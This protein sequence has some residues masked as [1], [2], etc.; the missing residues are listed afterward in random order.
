MSAFLIFP[1]QLFEETLAQEAAIFYVVES[2]LFFKQYAFHKQKILFHRA[3]MRAFADRLRATGKT[4]EYIDSL[5]PRASE[6]ALVSSISGPIALFDPNDYLLERRLRRAG[7]IH[8]V[9][10]PNFLNTDTSLLGTRKPYFQTAFYT[11]QR[12]DRGILLEEDGKPMGGQWTFDADNRK[13]IPKNTFIP[14]PF[15]ETAPNEYILEAIDYVT[16]NFSDNPGSLERPFS[17]AYYPVTHDEAQAALDQFI[18]ERIPLFGDYEDAIKAQEKTL[19]H[20]IL[21]PLINVGLLNPAQVIE[22][23]AASAAPLNSE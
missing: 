14:A 10:S 5:D 11:Q 8:L 18:R 22:R 6:V 17:G 19:F 2:E 23:V 16:A 12:K 4:V 3:S 13:K 7:N 20:S 9:A 1:H 21:S 15:P